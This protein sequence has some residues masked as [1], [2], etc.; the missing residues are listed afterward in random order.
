M[1][2]DVSGLPFTPVLPSSLEEDKSTNSSRE[3]FTMIGVVAEVYPPTDARNKSKNQYEYLVNCTGKL[4]TYKPV[5]CILRDKFGGGNDFE[6]YTLRLGQRVV[7]ECMLGSPEDGIIIG[8]VRNLTQQFNDVANGHFWMR[9]FSKITNNIDKDSTY[10]VKHDD[11]NEVRVEE[12][13]I[14]LTDGEKMV[15]TIDKEAKKITITDGEDTLVFDQSA[16]TVD[17]KAGKLTVNI[18]GEATVKAG[19]KVKVD[20]SKIELNGGGGA[21]LT[22]KTQTYCWVSGIPFKGQKNVVAG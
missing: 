11:G 14:K 7:V 15:I 16:K 2:G 17:L 3:Q 4:N 1:L 19:G 9:R 21:V 5:Q 13:K 8:G 10:S 20:G 6:T 22:E 18:D 12:K